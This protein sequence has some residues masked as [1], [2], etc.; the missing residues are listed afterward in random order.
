MAKLAIRGGTPVHRTGFPAWPRVTD[1]DRAQLEGILKNGYRRGEYV[2]E[3]ERKFGAYCGVKHC[4]AVANGTVSLELI[5]RALG[6]GYG[7]DVILSPYTFIATMSAIVYAGA[8]PVFADIDRE[9]YN[10]DPADLEKRI[11]P[12]TKAVIVTAVAGRPTD[13]DAFEALAEKYGFTYII[14]AAQAVGARWKDVSLCKYGIAASISCQNSKNLTAGEGGFITT[15]DDELA[16]GIRTILAGG[17]KNGVYVSVG[18]FNAMNDRQAALMLTQLGKLDGE[19]KLRERNAAYLD[20][21]LRTIPFASPTSHD[22]RISTHG[23][24][25]YMLRFHEDVLAEKGLDRDKM[26]AALQ[27]EGV[28]VT[29]GYSPLYRFGCVGAELTE[30]IVGGKID[31]SEL[32]E[33]AYASDHE[34]SWMY[35]A[36]LLGSFGDMDD[37]ADALVKVWDNA[38]ELN[39]N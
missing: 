31:T 34:G 35:Q 13:S 32:P 3:L 19:I 38:D 15:D 8:R 33:C 14:D 16:D 12:N 27:A 6:I 4:I 25:L 24:H 36:T 2:S 9:T 29:P 7:D 11:T 10:M 1:A 22:P 21:L 26:L 20:G 28:P 5:L 30:K 37:I 17:A 39:Q 23:Y 18:Q